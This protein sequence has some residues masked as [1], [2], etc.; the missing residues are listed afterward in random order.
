MVLLLEPKPIVYPINL[1]QYLGELGMQCRSASQNAQISV[2]EIARAQPESIVIS[3]V[4]CIRKTHGEFW[5]RPD[6]PLGRKISDLGVCLGPSSHRRRVRWQS[7][8]AL[9]DFSRKTSQITTMAK[10]IF[11]N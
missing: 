10:N 3:P 8:L 11:R 9:Q 4:P 5:H 1:A 7:H 2:E 6:S